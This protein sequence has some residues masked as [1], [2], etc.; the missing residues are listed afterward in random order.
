MEP[1][2]ELNPSAENMAVYICEK[3]QD[4]LAAVGRMPVEVAEVKVW[5]TDIQS[6]TYRPSNVASAVR[7]DK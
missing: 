7:P 3:M 1:F 6:A 5:E 2:T 4:G